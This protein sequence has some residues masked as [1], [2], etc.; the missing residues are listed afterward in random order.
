MKR[1]VGLKG[2]L[3]NH[4]SFW[5]SIHPVRRRCGSSKYAK[6]KLINP[7]EFQPNNNL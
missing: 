5:T 3:K 6:Q 1:S 2:T 7:P 4:F